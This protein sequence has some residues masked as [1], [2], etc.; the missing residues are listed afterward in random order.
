MPHEVFISYVS[1][2][3]SIAETVRLCL[4]EAGVHCWIASRD[5]VAA[6]DGSKAIAASRLLVLIFSAHANASE[7]ISRELMLAAENRLVI[8]P[9]MIDK[10]SPEPAK[11]YYLSRTHW[12]TVSDPPTLEQFQ[13]LVL[14]VEEI[15]KGVVESSDREAVP[16]R[17]KR[18]AGLRLLRIGGA[19]LYAGLIGWAV[20]AFVTHTVLNPFLT[21]TMVVETPTVTS[22]PLFAGLAL[23]PTSSPVLPTSSPLE[24]PTPASEY[25]RAHAFADPVL[26]A[27][28]SRAPIFQDDF[29]FPASHWKVNQ[30]GYAVLNGIAF[31]DFVLDVKQLASPQTDTGAVLEFRWSSKGG[32]QLRIDMNGEIFFTR[33]DGSITDLM[34]GL[35]RYLVNGAA[36]GNRIQ[37]IAQGGHICL[38]FNG[39]PYTLLTDP[40]FSAQ[41]SLALYMGNHSVQDLQSYWGSLKIWDITGLSTTP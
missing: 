10:V 15:L 36:R 18:V 40:D 39:E 34:L 41:G 37:V 1:E 2:D 35:P 27:L 11:L 14:R 7:Q 32:Y 28:T 22:T 24:T 23:T 19:V 9:F 17:W 20:L 3:A 31:Y 26:A 29:S 13:S 33:Q 25:Q 21:P 16:V 12:L 30:Q 4:E 38:L 6:E 5:L 8:V